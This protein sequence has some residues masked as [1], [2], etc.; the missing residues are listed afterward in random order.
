MRLR[1]SL[2]MALAIVVVPIA[3]Y[4]AF[5]SWDIYRVR[6]ICKAIRPGISVDAAR[7]IVKDWGL[8]SWLPK[9]DGA[10][11]NGVRDDQ[12]GTWFFAIPAASTMGDVTCG[13]SH[14]GRVIVSVDLLEW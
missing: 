8:E 12:D 9:P 4:F 3:A 2:A 14:D 7:L 5:V 13:I 10:Y 1:S 6:S 11:P